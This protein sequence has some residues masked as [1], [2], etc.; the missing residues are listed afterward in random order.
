MPPLSHLR[1]PGG[2]LD[3]AM[4]GVGGGSGKAAAGASRTAS[5][6]SGCLS[7]LDRIGARASSTLGAR[8]GGSGSRGVCGGQPPSRGSSRAATRQQLKSPPVS[9]A[10]APSSGGRAA[11]PTTA[12]AAASSAS[13]RGGGGGSGSGGGGS[14]SSSG[15]G[16]GGAPAG[17]DV[18]LKCD[19]CDGNHPTDSCPWFKKPRDKHP[20]AK[21]ASEKKLLGMQSGPVEVLRHGTVRV[22]RQP[23]DGARA[24]WR[25][26]LL[27]AI[28]S[29]P[30]HPLAPPCRP[31]AL[32]P[33]PCHR[34][35]AAAA[36]IP[37]PPSRRRHPAAAIPPPTR[38]PRF[39]SLP[40]GPV[41]SAQVR[42]STTHSRTGC[43]TA[44]RRR[45]CGGR[46]P[47]SYRRTRHSTSPTRR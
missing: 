31:V 32:S 30:T 47:I 40:T 11:T 15:G 3:A 41:R 13:C 34:R 45:R 33:L 28:A 17:A 42:A 7:T 8:S 6:R 38:S 12:A 29:P 5:T 46:W 36:T 35:R 14:A 20:D 39:T 23:G 18:K 43:G 26:G 19:K 22:H 1:R 4:R 10:A 25:V 37:P 9:A 21:P 44:R 24:S 27:G 16:G 2:A